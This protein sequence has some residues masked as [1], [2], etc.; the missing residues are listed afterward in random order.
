MSVPIHEIRS[1]ITPLRAI[2]WGGLL[3]LIDIYYKQLLNGEGW[4]FDILSDVVGALMIVW[5]VYRLSLVRVSGSYLTAVM[6]VLTIAGLA[7]VD[8]VHGHFVYQKPQW[9][10]L[11]MHIYGIAAYC[12]YVVFCMAMRTLCRAGGLVESERSWRTT[13]LLFLFICLIPLGLLN[14]VSAIVTLSGKSL[15][16][17]IP[18]VLMVLVVLFIAPWIHLFV[19]TSRMTREAAR[20]ISESEQ[21]LFVPESVRIHERPL[22]G[23]MAAAHGAA[24]HPLRSLSEAKAAHDGTVI[25]EGDHGGQVYVVARAAYLQCDESALEQLLADLDALVWNDPDSRRIYFERLPVGS[26]VPGGMGG[27]QV[28][29]SIWIHPEFNDKGLAPAIEGVLRGLRPRVH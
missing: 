2:F 14:A 8:A 12:A 3:C 21:K 26:G 22:G 10:S 20:K 17:D 5:G 27:G 15:S 24:F 28:T 18:P 4:R 29:E 16:F 25:L 6:F 19:S 13:M 1:T 23:F 7:V 9:L 11:L